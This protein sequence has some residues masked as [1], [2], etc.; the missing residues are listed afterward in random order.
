MTSIAAYD[1]D[2]A[3]Y[4][5]GSENELRFRILKNYISFTA[6]PSDL[7]TAVFLRST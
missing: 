2:H 1:R 7:E 4:S 6:I 3:H 5:Q